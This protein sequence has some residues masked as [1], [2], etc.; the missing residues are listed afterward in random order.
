[1]AGPMSSTPQILRLAPD[2]MVRPMAEGSVVL[3]GDDPPAVVGALHE[4]LLAVC[5]RPTERD[6]LVE[7]MCDLGEFDEVS[8]RTAIDELVEQRLLAEP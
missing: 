6:E 7:V 8:V 5:G 4:R 1:V 2:V 3:V